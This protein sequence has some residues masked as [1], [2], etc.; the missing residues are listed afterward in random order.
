MNDDTGVM[1]EIP[2]ELNHGVLWELRH[3][4]E[5]M[6][7]VGFAQ[8]IVALSFLDALSLLGKVPAWTSTP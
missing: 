4:L 3:S 6:A 2:R 7:V 1:L 8:L 5:G